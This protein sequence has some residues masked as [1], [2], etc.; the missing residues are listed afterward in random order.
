MEKVDTDF[1]HP[2]LPGHFC[3]VNTYRSSLWVG[4]GSGWPSQEEKQMGTGAQGDW[5]GSHSLVVMVD[6]KHE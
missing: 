4:S 6:L 1:P 2:V 5:F 3:C